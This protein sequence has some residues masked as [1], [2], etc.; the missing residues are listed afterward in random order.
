MTN[1]KQYLIA[2]I[3][4]IV[5]NLSA[6]EKYLQ[7]RSITVSY[8]DST[9]YCTLIKKEAHTSEGCKMAIYNRGK[10]HHVEALIPGFP[11]NGVYEVYDKNQNIIRLGNYKRGLKHGTWIQFSVDGAIVRKQEWKN[12]KLK[13][14]KNDKNVT[15]SEELSKSFNRKGWFKKIFKRDK[16]KDT[17]I[18]NETLKTDTVSEKAI[19]KDKST[20]WFKR[21]FRKKVRNPENKNLEV[22][23]GN[24]N[25]T[26]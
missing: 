1:K 21:I 22:E 24:V 12:G 3:L 5:N 4:L 17:T 23:K 19:K 25:N 7:T 11:L 16:Q 18:T 26:I 2:I 6:Q 8:T 15:S 13:R 20:S 10:I 14:A 9:I